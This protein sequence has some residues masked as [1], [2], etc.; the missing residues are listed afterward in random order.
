MVG[1]VDDTTTDA[2]VSLRLAYDARGFPGA[3]DPRFLTLGTT[4]YGNQLWSRDVFH[5]RQ[6]MAIQPGAV[7]SETNAYLCF[8]TDEGGV[9]QAATWYDL[10]RDPL[11]GRADR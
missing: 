9:E 11:Q 4:S 2:F 8:S 5:E 1:F 7:V 3:Y 6:E 10:L